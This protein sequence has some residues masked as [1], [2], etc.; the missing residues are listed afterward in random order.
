MGWTKEIKQGLSPI[1]DLVY[2][3]RCPLCGQA[4][5]AQGGLC[6]DCWSGI[7]APGEPACSACQKPI[8]E[9]ARSNG[10]CWQCREEPP[11]HAGVLAATIYNDVSRQMVLAFKRGGKLGL[12]GLLGQM[13]AQRIPDPMPHEEV[14][15]VPVPLHRLRLWE[16]G[17]NQTALLARE[18]AQRGKGTLCVDALK[19][20]KRTPSLGGLGSE[21]RKEALKGAIS[22]SSARRSA[23]AGADVILVDDVLTSG[24]TSNACV[25]ALLEGGAR[26]VRIACF[27]RVA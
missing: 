22:V 14:L 6:L 15:L 11:A 18:L 1:V 17:F 3:L 9:S 13:M 19:R 24:A 12:A 27:A 7:E 23:I 16:R 20:T 8:A 2:P 4:V 21:A 10:L 26:R 5:A 25:Q